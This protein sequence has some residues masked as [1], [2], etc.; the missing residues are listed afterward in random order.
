[1]DVNGRIGDWVG[2]RR[3][4]RAWERNQQ[5]DTNKRSN[6]RIVL[7]SNFD[8]KSEITV[9]MTSMNTHSIAMIETMK[10]VMP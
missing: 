1:M 4:R 9:R 8:L 5:N 7:I 2:E 3:D 10:V 6:K